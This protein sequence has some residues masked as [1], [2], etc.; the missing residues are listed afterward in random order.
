MCEILCNVCGR[1]DELPFDHD[2]EYIIC[3]NRRPQ[4]K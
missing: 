3:K 2:I 1:N 4:N